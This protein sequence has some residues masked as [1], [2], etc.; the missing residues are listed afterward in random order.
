MPFETLHPPDGS[1][2]FVID[3]AILAVPRGGPVAGPL[4]RSVDDCR[5]P[6]SGDVGSGGRIRTCDIPVRSRML[7]PSGLRARDG[8]T[9]QPN[10][11]P[12]LS[13]RP[14]PAPGPCGTREGTPKK[15][16][17]ACRIRTDDLGIEGP[18]S[19]RLV[20]AAEKMAPVEAGII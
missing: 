11:S 19:C 10:V 15:V 17:T 20:N 6:K 1:L 2:P 13:V 14:R 5:L 8:P 12:T 16:G 4:A 18:T 3:A 9:R 7:Y